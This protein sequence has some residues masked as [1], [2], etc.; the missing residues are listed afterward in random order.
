VRLADTARE[1]GATGPEQLALLLDGAVARTRV[2]NTDS[3]PTAPAIAAVLVDKAI[4]TSAWES[5]HTTVG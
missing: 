1:A 5:A 4:P 3:F 2:L